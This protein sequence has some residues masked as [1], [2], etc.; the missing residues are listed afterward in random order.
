MKTLNKTPY[1]DVYPTCERAVAKLR[2]YPG[3]LTP[4]QVS[5]IL[6]IQP[7]SSQTIGE[8]H[9]NSHG[10]E[11]VPT[12]NG[13]FLS[14]EGHSSS[15]D[16]RRHLDWLLDVLEPK[17]AELT[18]LLSSDGVSAH[19]YCIWWSVAGQGGPI[20]WPSHMRRM[21]DLGLECQFDIGFFGDDDEE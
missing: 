21:A 10:R 19:V 17:A 14:S 1:D 9:V 13:W 18:Q 6:C 11:R 15:L 12:I 2:I 5:N 3:A 20:L 4:R 7:S 8:R 16:L